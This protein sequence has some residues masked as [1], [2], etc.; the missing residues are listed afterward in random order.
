MESIHIT[1]NIEQ[2]LK[3]NIS[4]V[5]ICNLCGGADGIRR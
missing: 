4:I 2:H 1:E 3:H 5:H